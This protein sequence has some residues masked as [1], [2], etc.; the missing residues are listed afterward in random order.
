MISKMMTLGGLVL[1]RVLLDLSTHLE[2]YVAFDFGVK[3]STNP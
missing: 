2:T 1:L 3:Q